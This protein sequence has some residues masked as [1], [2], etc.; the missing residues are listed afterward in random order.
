MSKFKYFDEFLDLFHEPRQKTANGWLVRC[1]AHNDNGPSLSV[2]PVDG[3]VLVKCMA[4]CTTP[5]VCKALN[6]EMSD[7]FFDIGEKDRKHER[8]GPGEIQKT[9]DYQ[10]ESGE[11]L[12]QVVRYVPKSFR[13]RRPD[14]N[15]G[16]VWNLKGITPVLYRLPDVKRALVEN[17]DIFLVEGEKDAD[18]LQAIGLTATTCPMGAGKW[19]ETYSETLRGACVIILQDA[20]SAGRKHAGLVALAL[21][22]KAASLKVLPAFD[23]KD[24]SDWLIA[25]H[26]RAELEEIVSKTPEYQIE[27]PFPV[28]PKNKGGDGSYT[29]R[30]GKH[31]RLVH[32]RETE[33][34]DHVPLCNFTALI[35]DDFQK[36]DGQEVKRWYR[37]TGK[38]HTGKELPPVEIEA[39][40]FASMG[41]LPEAWGSDAQ[42]YVGNMYERHV[43]A[44]IR[45][46]SQSIRQRHIYTHTGW[47]VREHDR[48]FLTQAGAIG[49]DSLIVDMDDRLKRYSISKPTIDPQSAFR[50]SLE[51]L[52][53]ASRAITL[54]LWAS[55]YLAPLTEVLDPAFT[56]WGIAT[57]G[58]MKTTL[59][60]LA[61]S[62]FGEFDY[63]HVPSSWESTVNRLEHLAFLAKDIPLV[64][65]D[66]PPKHDA[67]SHRQQQVKAQT[68]IQKIGNRDTRGRMSPGGKAQRDFYPR[69]LIMSSGE[70]YPGGHGT[71]AR[72]I[73]LKF[74]KALVSFPLLTKEQHN[75]HS[76]RA[77]MYYYLAW[78]REGWA[79]ITS[80]MRGFFEEARDRARKAAGGVHSRLPEEVATLYI[81]MTTGL[82]AARHY[83]AI[84]QAE[85]DRLAV[86]AWDILID[87]SLEHGQSIEEERPAKRFLEALCTEIEIKNATLKEKGGF[88]PDVPT[89]GQTIIGYTD[90]MNPGVVYLLTGAAYSV[91]AR[92][93]LR[94]GQYFPFRPKTVWTDMEQQGYLL[95]RGEKARAIPTELDGSTKRVLY[96]KRGVLDP[97]IQYLSGFDINGDSEDGNVMQ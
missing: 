93:Y 94:Q 86:E 17:K 37:V 97:A 14:G 22:G 13:Q 51:F 49:D 60:S 16:W 90:V 10:D 8:Q 64:I 79:E 1:P 18:N 28:T 45:S 7:L 54:P 43:A 65:D 42:V 83:D 63:K 75:T 35:T 11:L 57:S 6:I 69:G 91:V 34:W 56:I 87:I 92:Y 9:Y 30:E 32:N 36:D 20:D 80:D 47:L 23:V 26:T 74:S 82:R 44:A 15:G 5:D 31:C 70:D 19:H 2:T 27:S 73:P 84:D 66:L 39:A 3:K 29:V 48:V 50:G 38:T 72:Y 71:S 85:A 12:F 62:H 76:Y 58:N 96:L 21:H 78:L 33:D 67:M 52:D 24:V 68:L 25:G 77:A 55:M 53:V 88:L 46:E 61:L 40:K 89:P 41:W 95:S 59:M 81:G 4:G